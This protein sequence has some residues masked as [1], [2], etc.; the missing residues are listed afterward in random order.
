MSEFCLEVSMFGV[1]WSDPQTLWL[2]IINLSLGLVTLVCV[3]A[4]GY[5]VF[6]DVR[7]RARKRAIARAMD[8]KAD[9]LGNSFGDHAFD[10]PGLGFTMADG[11]EPLKEPAQSPRT[12]SKASTKTPRKTGK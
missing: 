3:A 5:G 6:Q 10:M 8:R 1:N 12:P 9:A 2:N 7:A 11:G 4:I